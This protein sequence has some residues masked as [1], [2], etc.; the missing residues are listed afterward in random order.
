ME[1][2]FINNSA[3]IVG[4]IHNP[5][6]I[7]ESFLERVGILNN[8]DDLNRANLLITPAISQFIIKDI[9]LFII[10]PEK[11]RITSSILNEEPFDFANKYC[12]ALPHIKC[13]AIGIN[14]AIKIIDS[15]INKWFEKHNLVNINNS[16][17]AF[18]NYT[19]PIKSNVSCN[20]KVKENEGTAFV[21]FN[22]HHKFEET[23]L[24]DINL[25]FIE[26]W[27]EYKSL[28]EDFLSKI[29]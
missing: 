9:I 21:D 24:S 5:S 19:V 15:G 27:K 11:I 2:K 10:E 26:R 17:V 23:P 7:S 14:Y 1:H 18:I 3:V 25:N 20:I 4:N 6:L 13:R 22:F 29:F 8:P 12:E 28:Y 16:K